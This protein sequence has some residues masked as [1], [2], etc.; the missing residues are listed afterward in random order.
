MPHAPLFPCFRA[1]SKHAPSCIDPASPAIQSALP[2]ALPAPRSWRPADLRLDSIRLPPGFA[3]EQY[4]DSFIPA[5]FLALGLAEEGVTVVYASTA[6]ENAV[7][8]IVDRHDGSPREACVLLHN[9]PS[10]TQPNGAGA[11]ALWVGAHLQCGSW[12]GVGLLLTAL[13]LHCACCR[14]RI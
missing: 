5:R 14:Y 6:E 1:C 11:C 7:F 2:A 4:A 10:I 12:V 13:S 3:I 8:A 9:L